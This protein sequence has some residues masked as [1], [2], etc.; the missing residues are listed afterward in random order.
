MPAAYHP[1]LLDVARL[2]AKELARR[3]GIS[4]AE[5]LRRGLEKAV[6]GQPSNKPWMRYAG[7][8]AGRPNDSSSV[9]EIVYGRDR[10]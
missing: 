3:Q 7:I 4:L 10:P 1:R 5:L 8:V 6:A 9:D 2:A